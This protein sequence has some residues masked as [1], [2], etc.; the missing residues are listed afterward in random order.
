MPPSSQQTWIRRGWRFE[1]NLS[2]VL[3]ARVRLSHITSLSN[4]RAYAKVTVSMQHERVL[5]IFKFGQRQHIEQFVQGQL[6]M[7][8]L[9]HFANIERSRVR[10]DEHEGQAFWMQPATATISMQINGEFGPIPGITGP[11]AFSHPSELA[12]NVF[13]MYALRASVAKMLV[14]PRNIEFG[15]TFADVRDGDEFLR[16]VRIAAEKTGRETQWNLVEYVDKSVYHGPM[17]IFRKSSEFSYQSEFRI[18][19]LPG[20]GSPYKLEVGDLSDI[21]ISGPLRELNQ[22]MMV[23]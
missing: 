11:I 22:R 21:V 17:G 16:R 7:N 12:A 3:A 6:Y 18:A 14:D 10:H 9:A 1:G 19:I 13:C 4:G 8:T 15:D 23:E 2:V 20:T 5:G